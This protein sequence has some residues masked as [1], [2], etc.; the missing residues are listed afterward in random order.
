MHGITYGAITAVVVIIVSL[1]LYILDLHLNKSVSWIPSLF[2]IAGVVCGQ[3]NYKNKVLGGNI[4]CGRFFSS[5]F[6]II[7]FSCLV[8]MIYN[9]IFYKFIAPGVINEILDI[10]GQTIESHPEWNEEQVEQALEVSRRFS[11]PAMLS[12][13]GFF[14]QLLTVTILYLITN[15]IISHWI[16]YEKAGKKGWASIIPIYNIIVFLE[17]VKKPIWW[18]FLLIIPFINIFFA[19]WITNLL[20]KRFGKD[21]GYT[22]GLILL[23]FIFYPL[24]GFSDAEYIDEI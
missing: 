20:A 4:R 24:I 17:I 10:Q 21:E 1:V 11:S 6:M 15:L 19:I 22:I 13:I 5:G 23:P 9:F 12:I 3:I 7:L 2:L 16:I 8:L 14:T 18:T